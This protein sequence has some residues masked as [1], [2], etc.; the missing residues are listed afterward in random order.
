MN[1]EELPAD[2][3]W[4]RLLLTREQKFLYDL[5][6]LGKEKDKIQKVIIFIEGFLSNPF[7]AVF[8]FKTRL[9]AKKLARRAYWRVSPTFKRVCPRGTA[10]YEWKPWFGKSHLY[11][12]ND[13]FVGIARGGDREYILS[14]KKAYLKMKKNQH[15]ER[16]REL[17][18]QL[19]K[20]LQK[21]YD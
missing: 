14:W 5:N 17:Q 7:T 8:P 6:T 9:K 10:I 11:K 1:R 20:S 16:Q 4:K 19:N 12:A 15:E 2:I 18:Y 13:G 3:G 21:H